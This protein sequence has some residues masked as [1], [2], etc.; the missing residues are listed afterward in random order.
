MKHKIYSHLLAFLLCVALLSALPTAFAA[1]VP[2][3]AGSKVITGGQRNFKWPVPGNYGLTSCFLD[4]RRHYAIDI[5]ASQGTSVVAS[6]GGTVVE[7]YT[8]C[9]HNYGKSSNCCGSGFGNYVILQHDYL[10]KSGEYITLYTRYAHLTAA[11]VSEGQTVSAGTQVGTVGSTGY[12]TGHHLD[13]QI[14]YGGH[15]PFRDYSVDPYINE[16]LELPDE[17]YSAFSSSCCKEYVTYVKEL[18]PRCAHDSF[19]AE[20]ACTSCGYIFDWSATVD[21]GAMGIYTASTEITAPAIP[22]GGAPGSTTIP[23]GTEVTVTAAVTNGAYESWYQ[24]SMNGSTVYVPKASLTFSAYLASQ[25]T[26]SLSTLSEGQTLLKQSYH[27]SGYVSSR[28][29]LRKISGYIDGTYYGS[30]TG[31]GSNTYVDLSGTSINT[32]LYFSTLSPGKHTLTITATDASGRPEATVL[33]RIFY[34]ALPEA[35]VFTVTFDPGEGSCDPS[36]AAITDGNLLGTLPVPVRSDYVFTGWYT[37]DGT[38]VTADTVVTHSMTLYAHWAPATCRVT[39]GDKQ[40]EIAYGQAIGILPKTGKEGYQLVG[41]YTAE[42]GGSPVT[43]DTL[44]TEDLTLYPRWRPCQYRITLDPGEGIM[45][46]DT[47]TVIYGTAYGSLAAPKRSGYLFTGWLLSG[48]P[49]QGTDIVATAGDHTLTAGWEPLETVPPVTEEAMPDS[50]DTPSGKFPL[51]AVPAGLAM[52][53]AAVLSFFLLRQKQQAPAE[54][55][56]LTEETPNLEAPVSEEAS[57]EEPEP[58]TQE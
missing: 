11:C 28:Y 27:L 22:Y 15:T 36:S 35:A 3:Q 14:L 9:S 6:Y 21:T 33:S 20:G 32:K 4:N 45:P 47:K 1:S 29:P 53:C 51:W 58:V 18:Y 23:A 17:L 7:V 55:P 26:G 2:S 16:L 46:K 30:W 34:I 44:I 42:E 19:N 24:V 40:L 56:A 37:D 49:V 13:F 8:G 54:A 5:S 48:V 52:I 57:A 10:L 50:E 39:M 25:F 43:S 12:S 31:S 41:W 38:A